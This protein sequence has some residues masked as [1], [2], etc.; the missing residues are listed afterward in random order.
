[1]ATRFKVAV[2]GAGDMG[3]RHVEGWTLAGHDVVAIADIDLE[4][5]RAVAQ[6]HGIP[7]ARADYRALLDETDAEIVSVCTP[8]TLHAPI[9]IYAAERGKHVFCEKPL[10]P[11]FTEAAAMEAAVRQAG[12]Q[13]GIGFQRNLAEW[14]GLLTRW[15]QEGRF[16]RPLVF[17]SEA[18]AEVR[19]KRIMHDR[20]GNNGP[21]MDTG[22]HFYLLWQTVFQSR[23]TRVY[24]Q[25]R[26]LAQDR[27]EI[28]HIAERAIDT[29]VVTVEYAS[30]DIATWTVSWGLAARTQMRP[31]PDRVFGPNGG[32]ERE[33]GGLKRYQGD[34]VESVPLPAENLHEK[35]FACFAAAI[36]AGTAPPY[37]FQAGKEMLALTLAIFQSIDTGAVVPVS[38]DFA[39]DTASARARGGAP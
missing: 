35:E 8:L 12:V 20:H 30:G 25:G 1:M 23:P 27:P 26:V 32:A 2:I 11:S 3:T 37:G 29:A 24:A 15:V 18:L 34:Q 33:A 19:P 9:T 6:A 36:A 28:A 31:R 16:G 38:Y 21:L 5:A 7:T 39:A 14:V 22:C 13:F 4:R 10:A 17:N